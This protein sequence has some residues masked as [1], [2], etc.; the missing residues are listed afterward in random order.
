M[1]LGS[2]IFFCSPRQFHLLSFVLDFF[3]NGAYLPSSPVPEAERQF[4]GE[5]PPN[6]NTDDELK[7]QV[8]RLTQ[9]AGGLGGQGWSSEP[10]SKFSI[11]IFEK[12]LLIHVWIFSDDSQQQSNSATPSRS[13]INR[14]YAESAYSTNSSLSSSMCSTISQSTHNTNRARKRGF[15]DADINADI[16]A[17]N[18]RVASCAIVLLHDDVLVESAN[19][20][21][22][23]PLNEESVQ[24]LKIMADEYFSHVASLIVGMGLNDLLKAGELLDKSCNNHH[25]R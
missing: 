9:I 1:N 21:Y 22:G 11:W 14:R 24:K 23:C 8:D 2:L 18:I 6:T 15:I 4:D 17:L 13:Q 7:R 16:S 25:L 3:V 19:A 10:T 12:L 20:S 5:H